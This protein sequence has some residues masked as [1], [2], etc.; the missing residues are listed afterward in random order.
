VNE[1][2]AGRGSSSGATTLIAVIWLFTAL[3]CMAL[4]AL[5]LVAATSEESPAGVLRDL[6]GGSWAGSVSAFLARHLAA[7]GSAHVVLAAASAAAGLGLLRGRRWAP[8]LTIGLCYL[9]IVY[10]LLAGFHVL[11]VWWTAAGKLFA[12]EGPLLY[13]VG[14]SIM[15][16]LVTV[17]LISPL[18]IM[19]RHLRRS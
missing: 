2:R 13:Q 3:V 5:A 10:S 18:P 11:G 16:V 12:E 15:L 19:A 9:S 7:V 4:G 6:L 14:G 8:G 17:A 1:R